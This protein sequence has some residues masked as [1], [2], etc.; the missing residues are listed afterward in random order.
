MKLIKKQHVLMIHGIIQRLAKE[1]DNRIILFS[2]NGNDN[3]GSESRSVKN[4]DQFHHP[5]N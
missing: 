2:S 5:G 3:T 1:K 4:R